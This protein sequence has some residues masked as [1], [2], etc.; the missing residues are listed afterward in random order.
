MTISGITGIGTSFG[1]TA[2]AVGSSN[3]VSWSKSSNSASSASAATSLSAPYY[4]SPIYTIDPT[5]GAFVQEWRNS[6]TGAELYQSPSRASL[7]YGKAQ[8]LGHSA[9]SASSATQS[10]ARNSFSSSGFGQYGTQKGST[11][12]TFA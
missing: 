1:T 12:S 3:S 7:M 9:N 4:P 5:N 8:N 11:V 6:T 2:S 10:Y